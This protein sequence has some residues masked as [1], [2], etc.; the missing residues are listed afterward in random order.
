[1]CYEP[2]VLYAFLASLTTRI[3]L[4][5]GVIILLQ[6]QTALVAKQPA[7]LDILCRGRLRLGVGTGWFPFVDD[8]QLH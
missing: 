4:A 2:F 8:I 5:A 1:M 3:E 7:S 6:R